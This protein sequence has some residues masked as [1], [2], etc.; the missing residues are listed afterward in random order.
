MRAASRGIAS[1]LGISRYAVREVIC[2]GGAEVPHLE[3][4]GR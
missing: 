4:R 1:A 2:A 3:R